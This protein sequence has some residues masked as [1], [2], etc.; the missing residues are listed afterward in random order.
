[1]K[2]AYSLG[3]K[4]GAVPES[5]VLKAMRLLE[6][7]PKK[8]FKFLRKMELAYSPNVDVYYNMGV[9]LLHLNR[10]EDAMRY[11]EK[12]LRLE[13]NHEPARENLDQL[14]R[15]M[16]ILNKKCT[17]EDIEE[18]GTLANIARESKL[19]DIALRIGSI[20]VEVDSEKKGSLND[21][22][23]TYQAQKKF[24]EAAEYYDMALKIDPDMA[25]AL[26]NKAFC[27]LI[28]NR[29]DDAYRLCER[30]VELNPDFL[31]SWYHLGLIDINRANYDEALNHLNR[32]IELNDEYYLAWIAKYDLF[33]RMKKPEEAERCLDKAIELNPE[34]AAQIVLGKAGRIH[35]TNMHSKSHE[36]V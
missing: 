19:F 7:S 4:R 27:M 9:A 28:S 2:K 22:G 12:T 23:L 20:M 10:L 21:L 3:K 35:T 16:K 26:S 30:S 36:T 31:Q 18:M 1:M 33:C 25:E 8:G 15:I 32:A 29:L 11:F 13:E 5:R 6:Y 34:F 24:E 17:E 14:Q